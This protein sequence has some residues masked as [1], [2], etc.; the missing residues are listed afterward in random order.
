MARRI[1]SW[2]RKHRI[3]VDIPWSMDVPVDRPIDVSASKGKHNCPKAAATRKSP[4]Q[5]SLISS[6]SPSL[7]IKKKSVPRTRPK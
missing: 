1:P 5:S 7:V 2:K 4:Q 6:A 3:T